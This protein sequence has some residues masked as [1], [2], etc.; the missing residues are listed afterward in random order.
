MNTFIIFQLMI[1][2][3]TFMKEVLLQTIGMD[4]LCKFIDFGICLYT[5]WNNYKIAEHD[6]IMNIF[7]IFSSMIKKRKFSRTK[8]LLEA[9]NVNLLCKFI[10]FR[11]CL[12]IG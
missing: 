6:S 12:Y 1:R 5:G 4:T 2:K 10:E 8:M 3:T 11:I 7:I 9:I